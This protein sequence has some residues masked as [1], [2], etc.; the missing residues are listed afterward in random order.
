MADLRL[1]NASEDDDMNNELDNNERV[2]EDDER[3]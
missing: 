3:R 1:D 2:A